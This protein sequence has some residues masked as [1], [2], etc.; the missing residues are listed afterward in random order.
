MKENLRKCWAES[1]NLKACTGQPDKINEG[2]RCEAQ[3]P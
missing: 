1:K 3:T 2:H